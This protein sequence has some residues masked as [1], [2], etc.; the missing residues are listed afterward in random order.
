MAA[1]GYRGR[2][3][4]TKYELVAEVWTVVAPAALES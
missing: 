4:F 3:S 1:I 2:G